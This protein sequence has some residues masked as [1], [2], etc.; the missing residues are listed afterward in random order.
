MDSII[1]RFRNLWSKNEVEGYVMMNDKYRDMS[2]IMV[3]TGSNVWETKWY[4]NSDNIYKT[5]SQ[6]MSTIFSPSLTM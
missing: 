6:P 4:N 2:L 3:K 1:K 5:P